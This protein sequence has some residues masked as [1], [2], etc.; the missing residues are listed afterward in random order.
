[1]KKGILGLWVLGFS[2][3]VLANNFY[4][5]AQT[6]YDSYTT[7][8][9]HIFNIGSALQPSNYSAETSIHS[10]GI[11]GGIFA[12]YL[13]E[14]AKYNLA[15]ELNAATSSAKK[16]N[17]ASLNTS[18]PIGLISNT[19]R[20][21]ADVSESYAI[22]LLPGCNVSRNSL[23][24]LRLAAVNTNFNFFNNNPPFIIVN[25]PLDVSVNEHLWG[26]RIGVGTQYQI[27]RQIAIRGEYNYTAY[28]TPS[29][30]NLPASYDVGS[31][32]KFIPSSSQFVLSI[33]YQFGQQK[34]QIK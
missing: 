13:F 10:Q 32:L 31:E 2:S 33:V 16:T 1:M 14:N 17:V 12:G 27:K 26:G 11:Q 18:T 20:E 5:G 29:R 30:T 25:P 21:S 23:I 22:S 28:R 7:K 24:F 6:G 34:N 8:G 3:S 15:V 4:I 19:T 9:D